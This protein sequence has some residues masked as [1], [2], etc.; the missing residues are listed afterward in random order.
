MNSI[1]SHLRPKAPN[2]STDGDVWDDWE[3][4]TN[5]EHAEGVAR[6]AER[7][8]AEV[9][10]KGWGSFVGLLHDKGKE[11]RAFQEYIRQVN[12]LPANYHGED[13]SHAF[14]GAVLSRQCAPRT[15]PVAAYVIAGHHAGLCDYTK[16]RDYLAKTVPDE[17]T[18]L[19]A[20]NLPAKPSTPWTAADFNHLIRMLYSCLVDADYLDTEAFMNR[21]QAEARG[22]AE[23][24]PMLLPKL[25]ARLSV[26]VKNAPDTPVNRI[27]KQVQDVCRK[28]A[29]E[30]PGV[31]SLTVPTGG[32]KT[33]SSLLWAMLHAVEHGK[34][35]I[36]ISIP[37]T[38][39]IS[40]TAEV[41]RGIFGDENV[42]EHHS[43]VIH[44]ARGDEDTAAA[45][46]ALQKRLSAENWD[47]P[48]IV[49]TNV[50]LLESMY[51]SHASDC[52]KL[53][54][55]ANSVIIFD[56]AQTLPAE[57]LQPI[58]SALKVYQ[59]AFGVSLLFTTASQPTLQGRHEGMGREV[60]EGF[61]AVRE[62]VPREW[63]LH[64]QLRRVNL[65][66]LP[67]ALD[68]DAIARRM[69]TVR[70]VLCIVNTRKDA[71]EISQHLSTLEEDEEHFHLSRMMCPEH[72]D[73]TIGEIRRALKCDDE[74]PVRVVATQLIEAGVDID[75]PYVMRQEAGLDSVLQAA[76]RCNREGRMTELGRTEV[77]CIAGR[78]L[79]KGTLTYANQ[80]RKN[81][82][83]EGDLFASEAME[84]YFEQYYH[85]IKGF[86]TKDGELKMNMKD[87][88]GT[89]QELM[90]ETADRIFKL[91]NG[92]GVQIV[93]NYGES[94]KIVEA[95]RRQP[96][97]ALYRRL[98]R[99][100]VNLNEHDAG[101]LAESGMLEQLA[102]GYYYLSDP[103]QY[104]DR[105]GLKLDNHWL[106]E[107]CII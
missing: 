25:E 17:I 74:R 105:I 95:F 83:Y 66:I 13:K 24:L 70:R 87:A 85:Q 58:V 12:G 20:I 72:I 91:I 76:G 98:G 86:D 22:R 99:Y 93:V 26:I 56:E 15:Y 43:N 52:R 42:L 88:L 90:M 37:Y 106:E 47:F 51:A 45:K 84:E 34:R 11:R 41:L 75:F 64:E 27:R 19:P 38:S 35:R 101:L 59:K 107:T 33:L 2:N 6:L 53:H 65:S 44:E 102:E 68:Y 18:P 71:A 32:G 9:G 1:I 69:M 77:F 21:Q 62:I 94:A 55:V 10:L 31:Y 63:K 40:Q 39:I 54:N 81:M 36:I 30:A 50:R 92:Q 57:K 7:F 61:D 89:P 23:T 78:N 73:R 97:K 80:A 4:Q 49:T 46:V 16:L 5:E 48:I 100:I 60:L 96:C 8:A 79:P 82:R 103:R 28:M 67:K 29:T 14:V 104:D 3:V